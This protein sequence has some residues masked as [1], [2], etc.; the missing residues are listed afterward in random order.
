M[1]P[2]RPQYSGKL[3]RLLASRMIT[4]TCVERLE[5]SR[6]DRGS[7]PYGKSLRAHT[8]GTLIP[9]VVASNSLDLAIADTLVIANLD[10]FHNFHPSGDANN[11]GSCSSF[12]IISLSPCKNNGLLD[13]VPPLG[14]KK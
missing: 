7:A 1:T 10:K 6:G 13:S 3:T 12:H 5:K 8:F 11:S 2:R 14:Q 4:N 9:T